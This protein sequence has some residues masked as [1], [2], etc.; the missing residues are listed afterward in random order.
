MKHIKEKLKGEKKKKKASGTEIMYPQKV[1]NYRQVNQRNGQAKEL[2]VWLGL[3]EGHAG[4]SC[5]K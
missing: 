4:N 2:S 5:L 3:P 1:P